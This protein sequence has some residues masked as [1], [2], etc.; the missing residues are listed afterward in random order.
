[1]RLLLFCIVKYVEGNDEN[2]EEDNLFEEVT[3]NL[4]SA[5]YTEPVL[6]FG[7]CPVIY[8]WENG[9]SFKEITQITTFQEGSIVRTITRLNELCRAFQKAAIQM[10]NQLLNARSIKMYQTRYCL[11]WYFILGLVGKGS[12]HLAFLFIFFLS[13]GCVIYISRQNYRIVGVYFW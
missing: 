8:E 6:N 7:L 10:G 11:F 5:L 2:T 9:T 3:T 1:V 4:I 12:N 13:L